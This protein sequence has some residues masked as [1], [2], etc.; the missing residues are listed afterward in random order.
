MAQT[1]E[2][3]TSDQP[4][5]HYAIEL[6]VER[7]DHWREHRRPSRAARRNSQ[8]NTHIIGYIHKPRHDQRDTR[9]EPN[10]DDSGKECVHVS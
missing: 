1:A 4:R 10:N 6:K 3:P 2:R 5:T 8:E 9:N 7:T